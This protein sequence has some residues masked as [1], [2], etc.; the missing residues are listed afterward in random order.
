MIVSLVAA[1]AFFHSAPSKPAAAAD[2][3]AGQFTV[4]Y[5]RNNGQAQAGN[6]SE[7]VGRIFARLDRDSSGFLEQAEL[8]KSRFSVARAQGDAASPADA[9]PLEVDAWDDDRDKRLSADEFS[10]GM[11]TLSPRR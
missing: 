5:N 9:V 2:K 7:M 6:L 11:A 10:A 3:E 4:V 1:L 8:A